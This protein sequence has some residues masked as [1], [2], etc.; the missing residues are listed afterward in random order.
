MTPSVEALEA[1]EA[2]NH[3][4]VKKTAFFP[5]FDGLRAIALEARVRV[6][7]PALQAAR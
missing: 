1:A 4:T 5:G 3:E 6:L 7:N 2:R